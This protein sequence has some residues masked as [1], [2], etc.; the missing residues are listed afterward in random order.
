MQNQSLRRLRQIEGTSTTSVARNF[1][2]EGSMRC[3]VNVSVRPE[4][5]EQLGTKV[6]IKNMNSFSAMQQAIEFE[7]ARQSSLLEQGKESEIVQETRLF[8]EATQ[9]CSG[10]LQDMLVYNCE[11]CQV[12]CLAGV[13]QN[14]SV[15]QL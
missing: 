12:S 7:V 10:A 3:D 2:Q 11:V 5:A 14:T 6:E 15:I 1:V 4:G 9:A 13:A 8:D